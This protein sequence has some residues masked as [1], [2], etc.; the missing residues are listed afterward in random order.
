MS[1][2][3]FAD[4]TVTVDQ[5]IGCG[6]SLCLELKLVWGGRKKQAHHQD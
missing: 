2:P 3:P 6:A 4:K 5:Q 1:T